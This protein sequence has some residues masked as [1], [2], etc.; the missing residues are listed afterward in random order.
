MVVFFYHWI[1]RWIEMTMILGKDLSPNPILW[2]QRI[3]RSRSVE[4]VILEPLA[5]AAALVISMCQ[6][7]RE[8]LPSRFRL[9]RWVFS[10][11][12][13]LQSFSSLAF[14]SNWSTP[15]VDTIRSLPVIPSIKYFINVSSEVNLYSREQR[16]TAKY[17][18]HRFSYDNV[19]ERIKIK[20]RME[21]FLEYYTSIMTLFKFGLIVTPNGI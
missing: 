13:W 8:R 2:D 4:E 16:A 10:R 3:F 9:E 12:V 17:F 5:S 20:I 7:I 19:L 1:D 6:F 18:I 11:P 14:L 21:Y 15:K